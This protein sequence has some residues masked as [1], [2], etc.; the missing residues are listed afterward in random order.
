MKFLNNFPYSILGRLTEQDKIIYIYND[1]YG[2]VKINISTEI[3]KIGE[4][5]IKYNKKYIDYNII[6][7][8]K[9]SSIKPVDYDYNY[10]IFEE[11]GK[12]SFNLLL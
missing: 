11:N 7:E 12:Y 10:C 6:Y 3:E 2:I 5:A 8:A 4:N 1:K 9:Y